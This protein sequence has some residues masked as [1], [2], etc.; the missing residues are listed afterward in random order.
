MR[1]FWQQ[2]LQWF[3][4][5]GL[6]ALVLTCFVLAGCGTMAAS[7]AAE[8]RWQGDD[9]VRTREALGESRH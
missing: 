8:N 7:R 1:R 3:F 9:L 6:L 4:M 5:F 2:F